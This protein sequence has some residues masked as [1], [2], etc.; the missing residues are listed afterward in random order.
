MRRCLA[1]VFLTILAACA[2][3]APD[4]GLSSELKPWQPGSQLALPSHEP[5]DLTEYVL[6]GTD[7]ELRSSGAV[8]SGSA[9]V[10]YGSASGFEY[11]VYRVNPGLDAPDSVSVMLEEPATSGAWMGLA[12]YDSGKWEF[13]GPFIK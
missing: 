1:A 13:D 4:A 10:L 2:D 12:N 11:A 9:V 5:S 3:S 8:D 6:S 7:T